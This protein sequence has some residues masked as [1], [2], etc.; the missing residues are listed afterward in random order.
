MRDTEEF[1]KS[2]VVIELPINFCQ[3]PVFPERVFSLKYNEIV[4]NQ[5]SPVEVRKEQLIRE[6]VKVCARDLDF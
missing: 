1:L 5:K 2:Q 3:V 6:K 4:A